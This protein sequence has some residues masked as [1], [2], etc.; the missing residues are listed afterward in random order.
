MLWM[1]LYLWDGVMLGL[2][3]YCNKND[4]FLQV[5]WFFG[6][7]MCSKCWDGK[8]GCVVEVMLFV[9]GGVWKLIILFYLMIG[10]WCFMEL[11]WWVFNVIQFMFISQ[12]CELEVDGVV[13][14]YV[15]LEVLLKV[16]YELF[17]FG[18]MLVLVLLVMCEWG[19]IYCGY[20]SM[21][22]DCQS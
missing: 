17:E 16:E 6:V 10:K 5:L 9:I 4:D 3:F 20:G 19:E 14:C 8:S 21:E 12:L 13:I 2:C 18:C 7:C 1:V 15:Y 11:M 22:G